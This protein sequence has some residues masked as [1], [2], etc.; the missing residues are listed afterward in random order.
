MISTVR[1]LLYPVATL[2]FTCCLYA[3]ALAHPYTGSFGWEGIRPAVRDSA[4]LI[5]K[6]GRV[7]SGMVGISAKTP[8]QYRRRKWMMKHATRV[9]LDRLANHPDK[10]V[11]ITALEGLLFQP[12]TDVH[13]LFTKALL[14]TRTQIHFQSGC[15]GRMMGLGEYLVWRYVPELTDSPPIPPNGILERLSKPEQAEISRLYQ[16]RRV[17]W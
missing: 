10:A 17:K 4:L 14:D 7:T 12:E 9:E 13:G 1:F 3:A 5:Q 2:I 8:Q 6:D 15:T 16:Q 11:R